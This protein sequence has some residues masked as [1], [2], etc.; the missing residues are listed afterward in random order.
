VACHVT[1]STFFAFANDENQVVDSNAFARRISQGEGNVSP[2][3]RGNVGSKRTL[4][5]V[6]KNIAAS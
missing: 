3:K 4:R 1:K 2:K 6:M 5:R